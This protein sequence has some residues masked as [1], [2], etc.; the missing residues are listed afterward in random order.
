MRTTRQLQQHVPVQVHQ[1]DDRLVLAAPMPGLEPPDISVIV[2]GDRVTIH[3][4]YRG[5]WHGKLDD[6]RPFPLEVVDGTRGLRVGPMG[7]AIR[8][9]RPQSIGRK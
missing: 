3:R 4:D 5:A 7:S 8:P 2:R 1:A 6:R 9:T